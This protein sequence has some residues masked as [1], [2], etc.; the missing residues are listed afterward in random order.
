MHEELASNNHADSSRYIRSANRKKSHFKLSSNHFT[1]LSDGDFEAQLGSITKADP[2]NHTG[3]KALHKHKPVYVGRAPSP[4]DIP[5]ELDWRD[6][7]RLSSIIFTYA[8]TL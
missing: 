8:L 6:F 5:D 1:D 3:M 7:G 2:R 4:I